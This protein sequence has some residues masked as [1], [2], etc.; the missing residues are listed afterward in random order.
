MSLL[1]TIE[2]KMAAPIEAPPSVGVE[3]LDDKFSP[4]HLET[5]A[6]VRRALRGVK[7]RTADFSWLRAVSCV[8]T[9][10]ELQWT[11]DTV[12]DDRNRPGVPIPVRFGFMSSLCV[13][14]HRGGIQRMALE[15]LRHALREMILHELDECIYVDGERPFD[16]HPT[17]TIRGELVP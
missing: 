13:A 2:I 7:I 1:S 3:V 16:P 6:E 4:P 11:V 14:A 8:V 10:H 12:V 17:V 5:F 15:D 9:R